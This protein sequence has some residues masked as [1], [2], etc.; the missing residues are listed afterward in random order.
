MLHGRVCHIGIYRH[1]IED[2]CELK[3]WFDIGINLVSYLYELANVFKEV[4]YH[5]SGLLKCIGISN[6]LF[7]TETRSKEC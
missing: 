2:I 5:H 1:W 6:Q 7:L 4:K 3:T